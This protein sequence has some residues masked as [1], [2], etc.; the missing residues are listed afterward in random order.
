MPVLPGTI[1]AMRYI[2]FADS[3]R[4][5]A[6]TSGE[7]SVDCLS[8]IAETY[9]STQLERGFSALDFYKSLL[10]IDGYT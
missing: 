5:F 7:E 3:K 10:M 1:D 6:F 8:Q 2:C 4:L 9:L